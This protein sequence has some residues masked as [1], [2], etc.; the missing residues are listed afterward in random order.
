MIPTALPGE[1][2]LRFFAHA[3]A[4]LL[5]DRVP[6]TQGSRAVMR[7]PGV[8]LQHLD[9]RDY[10]PG[11]EIRHIDWRQTARSRRPVVRRFESE[12]VSAW[13]LVLDASSSMAAHSGAKWPAAARM[14]AALSYALL[15]LGHRV[16]VLAFGARVLSECA[17]GRGRHHYAAIARLLGAIRPAPASDRAELGVCAA[18][19]HGAESVFVLGDFLAADEMRNDLAA[20]RPRCVALHA[21]Q[22]RDDAETCLPEAGEIDLV[23]VETGDRMQAL[24]GA[25]ANAR[26]TAERAAMTVRLRAFCARSGIAFSDWDIV[27]PWQQALLQHLVRARSQC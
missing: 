22:V 8:G 17:S 11:D 6:R 16:G 13:T 5:V 18:H 2:E 10:V 20:L 26:A 24:A 27:Q 23:D 15:D 9:H 19:L 7:R 25:A 21:V 3:A 14:A 12:S 1:S 4:H